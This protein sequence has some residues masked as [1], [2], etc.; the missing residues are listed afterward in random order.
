MNKEIVKKIVAE[1]IVADILSNLNDRSGV[2]LDFDE[3][4]NEEIS[5]TLEGIVVKNLTPLD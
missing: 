4:V 1:K 2:N 5:K 3:E